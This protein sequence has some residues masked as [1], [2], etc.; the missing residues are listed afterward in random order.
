MKAKYSMYDVR[1]AL[2]REIAGALDE[3]YLTLDVEI[4]E[5]EVKEGTYFVK[6]VFKVTPLFS[7]TPRRKGKFEARLDEDLKI[8]SWKILEE[9]PQ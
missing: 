1:E 2:R 4:P 9:T 3:S 6:G 8:I 5:L 7:V